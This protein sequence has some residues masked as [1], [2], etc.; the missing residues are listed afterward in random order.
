MAHRFGKHTIWEA[1]KPPVRVTFQSQLRPMEKIVST[2]LEPNQELMSEMGP[3]VLIPG[4]LVMMQGL[5]GKLSSWLTKP[6]IQKPSITLMVSQLFLPLRTVAGQLTAAIK[7]SWLICTIRLGKS[8]SGWIKKLLV[9]M[10]KSPIRAPHLHLEIVV[11][12]ILLPVVRVRI[13][14]IHLQMV[15]L[16]EQ[17]KFHL[18]RLH[19]AIV[20]IIFQTA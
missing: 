11:H 7:P 4:L 20:L 13:V 17:V 18:M 10:E 6:S 16:M 19:G 1:L 14:A 5:W 15:L 3:V 2:Y 8:M 12:L 9:L